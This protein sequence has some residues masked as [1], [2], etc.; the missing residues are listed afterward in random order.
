MHTVR[1]ALERDVVVM[2]VPGSIR[3]TASEGPNQLI[4]EGAAPVAGVDDV[5]VALGLST[6]GASSSTASA[7]A[8]AE[9]SLEPEER[10]VLQAVDWTPTT[11]EDV[12]R[13]SGLD[14]A[15]AAARLN[16]LEMAG[17]VQN[18]PGWWERVAPLRGD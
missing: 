14:P 4:A 17:L 11:T 18:G 7:G 9:G 1:A 2:A 15:S 13:R 6:G 3:S 8:D 16:R 12:L 5:M 10:R